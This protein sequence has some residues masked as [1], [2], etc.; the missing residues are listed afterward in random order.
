MA[1]PMGGLFYQVSSP[2]TLI[3]DIESASA[4]DQSDLRSEIGDYEDLM[5]VDY[6]YCCAVEGVCQEGNLWISRNQQ[7]TGLR[8]ADLQRFKNVTWN[9]CVVK[10]FLTTRE[11]EVE[12]VGRSMFNIIQSLNLQWGNLQVMGMH[13]KIEAAERQVVIGTMEAGFLPHQ[14][15]VGAVARALRR[16]DHFSQYFCNAVGAQVVANTGRTPGLA[17]TM[18][19]TDMDYAYRDKALFYFQS[20]LQRHGALVSKCLQEVD[21]TDY[22]PRLSKLKIVRP[23]GSV[24]LQ[25]V[26]PGSAP[27]QQNNSQPIV[28]DQL[29]RHQIKDA[30]QDAARRAMEPMVVKLEQ[31]KI[32]DGL[33]DNMDRLLR[34]LDALN[35]NL[36]LAAVARV[37]VEFQRQ[38]RESVLALQAAL[39]QIDT[40]QMLVESKRLWQDMQAVQQYVT[41]CVEY[42][43]RAAQPLRTMPHLM[44]PSS[45]VAHGAPPPAAPPPEAHIPPGA[46]PTH[47]PAAHP[48]STAP[49]AHPLAAPTHPPAHTTVPPTTLP[50]L[51]PPQP[52]GTT[53]PPSAPRARPRTIG[54]AG[55]TDDGAVDG[56]ERGVS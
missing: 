45:V 18:Y 13:P 14:L 7:D 19:G 42:I 1:L 50:P 30:V 8:D 48:P 31:V 11:G 44:V 56:L 9:E 20:A 34:E 36:D 43:D 23:E 39:V 52:A 5:R 54:T 33:A 53:F 24:E 29:S 38:V 6:T 40:T 17:K 10:K 2:S 55:H 41:E 22:V 35:Q 15:D 21:S 32:P 12:F 27:Q 4:T 47:P 37:I 3:V 26:M 49:A 46:A 25:G 28:V 51:A 16:C